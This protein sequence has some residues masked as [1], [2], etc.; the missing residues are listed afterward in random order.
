MRSSSSDWASAS[1]V[2]VRQQRV[3]RRVEPAQHRATARRGVRPGRRPARRADGWRCRAPSRCPRRSGRCPS[4]TAP[5]VRLVKYA[6]SPGLA[7]SADV[8]GAVVAAAVRRHHEDGVGD[9]LAGQP[10]ERTGGPERVVGVVG[11]CP[12]G[13]GRYDE[14]R[15]RELGRQRGAAAGRVRRDVRRGGVRH[16]RAGVP[17]RARTP[18]ADG[19]ASGCRATPDSACSSAISRVYGASPTIRAVRDDIRC[20]GGTGQ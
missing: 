1:F 5:C 7:Y 9:R 16:R 13:A 12:H 20:P 10:G 17:V 15:A 19:R 14:K 6:A 2:A 18:R 11:P 4:Q 8:E 3:N